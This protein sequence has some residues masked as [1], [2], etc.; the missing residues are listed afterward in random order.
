[1]PAPISMNAPFSEEESGPGRGRRPSDRQSG[2]G[3]TVAIQ[4]VVILLVNKLF[5]FS[6]T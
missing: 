1:M 5:A 4:V 2:K 6:N 3:G